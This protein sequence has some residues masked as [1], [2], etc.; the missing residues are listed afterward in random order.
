[1]KVIL[2]TNIWISSIL[3]PQSIP[4]RIVTAWQQ[5]LF[6]VVTSNPILDEIEKILNYPKIQKRLTVSNEEII[7]FLTF[8]RLFT[9][10]IELKPSE[11]M[12]T[13]LRDL[14]D[15]PILETLLLS[16]SEYLITG[17]QD[18]LVL[19]KQYPIITANEFINL[20]QA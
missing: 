15:I 12:I 8:I 3:L 19:C 10:V 7:E 1:M 9:D 5:S 13:E 18:L 17:D 6:N 11:K 2:D 14:N 16:E 20:F 4:G